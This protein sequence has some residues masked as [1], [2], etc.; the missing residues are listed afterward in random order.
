MQCPSCG[1]KQ[2]SHVECERCGIIFAKY[3]IR[4]QQLTD[5]KTAKEELAQKKKGSTS[6][7]VIGLVIG[8]AIG[9]GAFLYLGG[10]S[11]T[12]SPQSEITTVTPPIHSR[13]KQPESIR[14]QQ[15][16]PPALQSGNSSLEGLA[17]QLNEKY[18][19]NNPIGKAR[20]ATVYIKTTWGSG[21]GFFVTDNGLIITNRH[22][23]QMQ[24][25]ELNALNANAAKGAKALAS[26]KKRIHYL[27]SKVSQVRDQEMRQQVLEDIRTREQDFVKY[28]RLHQQ[29]LDKISDIEMASPT[30]DVKVILIDGSTWP[31][32][33]VT[34]SDRHDL[35]LVSINAYSSPYLSV[36]HG[37]R[38]Q[39]ERVYTVGN[40]HGLRHTVTSGVI[41]GY[42]TYNNEPFIQTDAPI[43][44][45][46]SG[47]PLIDETGD[48]LGVNTM[49]IRD[50]EGIGFAI[51]MASV[52]EEFGN[53]LSAD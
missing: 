25:K 39:G 4:Q 18:P 20:N 49:I 16:T 14:Q 36:S 9:G 34:I 26:E 41:S 53:Y 29:L 19:A 13:E 37:A 31:V 30:D 17:A 3:T 21:S 38:G 43:N 51:P 22:V 24:D 47:G 7:L 46:N 10:S 12:T 45:G 44:P 11:K 35:A 48:V 32:S 52:L 5:A 15:P 6:G 2:R 27:K 28:K 50:T 42:R 8:L 23:L 40:P 33:S 1:N